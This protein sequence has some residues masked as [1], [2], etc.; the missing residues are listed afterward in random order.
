MWGKPDQIKQRGNALAQFV[1]RHAREP[2]VQ[3][4]EFRGGQPIVEAEIFGKEANFPPHFHVAQRR[5]ENSRLPAARPDEPQ[6]H[7]DRGALAR[8]VGPRKPKISPRRTDNERSRTATLSPK[9][10]RKFASGGEVI[11]IIQRRFRSGTS[12][13]LEAHL[14]ESASAMAWLESPK[15]TS[16]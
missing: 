16:E 1:R 14:S 11:R 5:A 13:C 7:L 9:T 2:T 8:S 15:P 3:L 12:R 4:E 6:E 10:F